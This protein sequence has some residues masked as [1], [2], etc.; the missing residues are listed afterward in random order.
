MDLTV[1]AA[2]C[3]LGAVIGAGAGAALFGAVGLGRESR[4]GGERDVTGACEGEGVG[5]LTSTR[6]KRARRLAGLPA[7]RQPERRAFDVSLQS[8][9]PVPG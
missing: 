7:A 4:Y 3:R 2:W 9:T 5:E 1:I 8:W 6:N